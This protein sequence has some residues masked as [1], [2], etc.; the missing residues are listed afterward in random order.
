MA[1]SM[2]FMNNALFWEISCFALAALLGMFL[3]FFIFVVARRTHAIKEIKSILTG[4]P[5]CLFFTD[6]K[7]VEWL[8]ITP[9]AG[10]VMSEKYG[11]FV[12]NEEGTYVDKTTKTVLIPFSAEIATGASVTAFADAQQIAAVLKDKKQ[13]SVIREMLSRGELDDHRFDCIKESVNFSELKGLMNTMVPHNITSLLN[14]MVSQQLGAMGKQ[15]VS[16]IYWAIL[17]IGLI[18]LMALV[19]WLVIGGKG[20]GSQAVSVTVSAAEIAKAMGS[21]VIS[22]AS[23]IAR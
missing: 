5:L 21:N 2:D 11:T 16:F 14:K 19:L 18:G 9:E 23:V 10:M 15:G 13:M 12:V 4:K 7:T 6:H 8:N 20:G 17:G 3:L 1:I 22:N